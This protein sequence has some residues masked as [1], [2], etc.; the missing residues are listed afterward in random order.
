[1]VFLRYIYVY[2]N[3]RFFFFASIQASKTQILNEFVNLRWFFFL[4]CFIRQR[5]DVHPWL[6]SWHVLCFEGKGRIVLRETRVAIFLYFCWKFWKLSSFSLKMLRIPNIKKKI[7]TN[8]DCFS[9]WMPTKIRCRSNPTE[10]DTLNGRLFLFYYKSLTVFL[11]HE[12]SF[13]YFAQWK[14][15]I[16]IKKDARD[17]DHSYYDWNVF[18]FDS[19]WRFWMSNLCCLSKRFSILI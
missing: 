8:F 5:D 16:I 15:G 14:T 19:L 1:M 4:S 18:F 10:T 9:W 3:F 17:H 6:A 7:T 11:N 2:E 13:F 12:G